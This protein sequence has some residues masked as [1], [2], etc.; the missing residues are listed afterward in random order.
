MFC[1]LA[2][3]T[4]IVLRFMEGMNGYRT[5]LH[6]EASMICQCP[7]R[8]GGGII[9]KSICTPLTHTCKYRN[10]GERKGG[11]HCCI[12][13]SVYFRRRVE[14]AQITYCTLHWCFRVIVSERH[15]KVLF[16]YLQALGQISKRKL[17]VY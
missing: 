8:R 14:Q 9:V 1:T 16:D 6:G 3:A 12:V 11:Q 13:L 15:Q 7:C 2:T 10:E 17:W 5:D 4:T